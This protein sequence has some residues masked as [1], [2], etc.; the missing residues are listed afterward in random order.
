MNG[1]IENVNVNTNM[2][3]ANGDFNKAYE[4]IT[5]S[6]TGDFYIGGVTGENSGVITKTSVNGKINVQ[7]CK[8][9]FVG[10][11]S[12]IGGKINTSYNEADIGISFAKNASV[13]GIVGYSTDTSKCYNIGN[14]YVGADEVRVGGIAGY[15]GDDAIN[16]C[17]N[18]GNI[19]GGYYN[20]TSFGL[21]NSG[22]ASFV[23]GIVGE[24]S[25]G[26]ENCYN[27]S[28]YI[29]SIAKNSN[30][31]S[32]ACIES[33]SNAEIKNC[34][35]VTDS[36]V[37]ENYDSTI[38]NNNKVVGE[39]KT[40]QDAGNSNNYSGFDFSD[41][42]IWE[43]PIYDEDNNNTYMPS[44]KDIPRDV[45]ISEKK[46]LNIYSDKEYTKNG[47]EVTY[48][49]DSN[50]SLKKLTNENIK[51]T[52]AKYIEGS[53]NI[54]ENNK[55]KATFKVSV[56]GNSNSD[57]I[58]T[59]ELTININGVSSSNNKVKIDNIAPTFDLELSETDWSNNDVAINVTGEKDTGI[60]LHSSAYS[61]NGGTW[62]TSNSY[63]VTTNGE[64][65]VKV[66]D[67]LGNEAE[68]TLDVNNIDKLS[69]SFNTLEYDDKNFKLTYSTKDAEDETGL[70]GCS[71]IN[72]VAYLKGDEYSS[73]ETF[74]NNNPI[75]LEKNDGI[76]S[77]KIYEEG[78]YTFCVKDN[79]GNYELK[80]LYVCPDPDDPDFKLYTGDPD[81]TMIDYD[82]NS[83]TN[84]SVYMKITCEK[85]GVSDPESYT[86]KI[87]KTTSDGESFIEEESGVKLD[88]YY[89][90]EDE[91]AEYT[92]TISVIAKYSDFVSGKISSTKYIRVDKEAPEIE[93]TN[94]NI[95]ST[96]E[97][98][99]TKIEVKDNLSG[100]SSEN[101][102]YY[103]VTKDA[104]VPTTWNTLSN[105][106]TA[107]EVGTKYDYGYKYVWIRE[108]IKDKAGNESNLKM[109]GYEFNNYVDAKIEI[110]NASESG[111]VYGNEI[112][113]VLETN[114]DI[115]ETYFYITH[116]EFI[117]KTKIDNEEIEYKEIEY[118]QYEESKDLKNYFV[119]YNGDGKNI[120]DNVTLATSKKGEVETTG[121]DRD[122]DDNV[123]SYYY[124]I[125]GVYDNQITIRVLFNKE[126]ITDD[127]TEDTE[128]YIKLK[129]GAFKDDK[130]RI[131][132]EIV[133]D[134]AI[135][136]QDTALPLVTINSI[137]DSKDRQITLGDSGI[138]SEIEY[139]IVLD[140]DREEQ[141][142]EK[143]LDT[144]EEHFSIAGSSVLV[145][146][147][148][149]E[150]TMIGKDEDGYDSSNPTGTYKLIV[151]IETDSSTGKIQPIISK[152]AISKTK[153]GKKYPS[154]Q[155]KGDF[156]E[157][158]KIG[159]VS[160]DGIVI[161][162]GYYL[163]GGTKDSGYVI[164][165]N[166]LDEYAYIDG[167]TWS[168]SK[169]TNDDDIKCIATRTWGAT[170]QYLNS[171]VDVGDN[172][173]DSYNGYTKDDPLQGNQYVWVPA[174]FPDE[175]TGVIGTEIG[176]IDNIESMIIYSTNNTGLQG[177]NA[178][179]RYEI[180][181]KN[182]EVIKVPTTG[183]Y[184]RDDFC[185]DSDNKY[186]P[187]LNKKW[188]VN[189]YTPSNL[190]DFLTDFQ[191]RKEYYIDNQDS[192]FS[193]SDGLDG[194]K[195][196]S[197]YHYKG[198]YIGRYRVRTENGSGTR[199][200]RQVCR[201]F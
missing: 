82:G 164:S 87:T 106:N 136:Y 26:V 19:E 54:N 75:S 201:L 163:V 121:V 70:N 67:K 159:N 63:N 92:I 43:K 178:G 182:G 153:D 3:I 7:F 165:D 171:Y 52:N 183:K 142:G 90:I 46:I 88:T 124:E 76:Y 113:Y 10:G 110:T 30:L 128:I 176:N 133:S 86:Y 17:F 40:V 127:L 101:T 195:V 6:K 95:V 45:I 66:R 23:G 114:A 51:I 49:V 196:K 89:L 138:N 72:Y 18:T 21:D 99:T 64:V 125:I 58:E 100:V 135:I 118:E 154:G 34:Y 12:G 42:C 185:D 98:V 1:T 148:T 155:A 13:G 83:W 152:G 11:I 134:K 102:Y 84:Q 24:T 192:Y 137:T 197:I 80:H 33:D 37:M 74:E 31:G 200:G 190:S 53:L 65:S 112:V 107:I 32:I 8:D 93:F 116:E 146:D 5:Q 173:R 198:F 85:D 9:A 151:K 149:Y 179:K 44:L 184:S 81:G 140:K 111:A 120:T 78:D 188:Y 96:G 162:S 61:F 71:G 169:I 181:L 15:D 108:G 94:Q 147:C 36:N 143:L 191:T 166:Q 2:S 157:V 62:S 35:I 132:R 193:V 126:E 4:G 170:K 144:L 167:H 194:E 25:Q 60:G 161:P 73:L 91:S 39:I 41:I 139:R 59:I 14:V 57:T 56:N 38:D 123:D 119:V 177:T 22:G 117:D 103:N 150:I 174:T 20:T 77:V 55:R 160:Y 186:T 141:N 129:E 172:F 122:G 104:E 27:I 50:V 47:E 69:P 79:A 180:T 97:Y 105:L 175:V 145:A 168:N 29:K 158:G 131:N 187:Y 68:E 109:I 156:I 189:N 199:R 130:G 16:N 48:N 115:D 28:P